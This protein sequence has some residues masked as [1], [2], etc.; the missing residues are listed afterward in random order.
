MPAGSSSDPGP[1]DP[2]RGVV[3]QIIHIY[4]LSPRFAQLFQNLIA[5]L[6]FNA[7]VF[8]FFKNVSLEGRPI[9][10]QMGKQGV[11]S[12]RQSFA[13]TCSSVNFR[14]ITVFEQI[15]WLKRVLKPFQWAD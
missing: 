9:G 5:K 4:V 11:G 3:R 13:D 12:E 6:L 15:Q 10:Q 2:G 1:A 14:K 8:L 7:I